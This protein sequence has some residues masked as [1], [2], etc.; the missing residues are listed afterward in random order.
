MNI[1]DLKVI[2]T[3]AASGLGKEI[4][5][6]LCRAGA[7]VAALDINQ[8][9]LEELKAEAKDLAGK[10]Y[11]YR[12]DVACESEVVEVTKNAFSDCMYINGLINCAGIYRDGLLITSYQQSFFKMPLAQWQKVIDVDL[13]GT[14]LM[15]REV[16]AQMIE[17]AITP[18][19]IINIS[20][21]SRHGNPGQSNYSAAKAGVVVDTRVW[22]Q[23]LASYGIR[24]A[25]IA[26]GFI[27]TPILQAMQPEVLD[28]WITKIPL[29]RLGEAC[30]IFDGVRFIVECDYFNGKCLEIDGGLNI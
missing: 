13:T 17:R 12:A 14:F 10:I 28:Q 6:S 7:T 2:V 15:T 20:S 22:A 11:S 25:A 21:I 16:A 9:G 27:H 24:V 4:S 18:A 26:P 3:G 8:T 23:E 19:V 30:E 29:G 5:L 1:Y